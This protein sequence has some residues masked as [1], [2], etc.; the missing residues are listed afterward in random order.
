MSPDIYPAY[1]N[2]KSFNIINSTTTCTNPIYIE[3]CSI[4]IYSV[5]P[6]KPKSPSFLEER[7]KCAIN[8]GGKEG[9]NPTK[10]PSTNKDGREWLAG[11]ASKLLEKGI[12][13]SAGGV[14][15]ELDNGGADT[16]AEEETLGNRGHAAVGRAEY[17]DSVGGSNVVNH[18]MRTHAH[19][20]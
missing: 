12:D 15:V 18:L 7:N 17:D 4:Y 20:W 10:E 3:Q 2:V 8:V 13:G 11:A 5:E 9:L 14:L 1:I 6:S 16:E 19:E